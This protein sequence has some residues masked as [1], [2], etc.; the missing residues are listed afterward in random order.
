M[1]RSLG[2]ICDLGWKIEHEIELCVLNMMFMIWLT[3]KQAIH[4]SLE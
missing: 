1:K 2:R 3:G 4:L